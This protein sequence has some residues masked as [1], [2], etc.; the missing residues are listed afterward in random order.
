MDALSDDRP[1]FYEVYMQQ[2]L[3]NMIF[4]SLKFTITILCEKYPALTNL[5][6][7]IT[8]VSSLLLGFINSISLFK[9]DATITE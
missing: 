8:K 6:Y 7:H 1:T 2:Q 5:R 9:S 3:E 4:D